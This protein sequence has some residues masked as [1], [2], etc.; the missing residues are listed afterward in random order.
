MI[1][2]HSSTLSGQIGR[3]CNGSND[4]DD[5]LRDAHADGAEQKEIAA[6]HLLD[7]VQARE[8]GSDVDRVGDDLDDKGILEAG[9]LK[10][11]GSIIEDKVDTCR[12]SVA[13]SGP[14]TRLHTGQLL[15]RLETTAGDESLEDGALETIDIAGLPHAHLIGVI[16]LN[17]CELL[18]DSR[19]VRVETTKP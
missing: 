11:L 17:L 7:E 13:I 4:G 2:L 18:H 9:I 15:Q 8:C 3:S 5:E 12:S 6:T 10:V 14:G 16:G 1:N 19:V